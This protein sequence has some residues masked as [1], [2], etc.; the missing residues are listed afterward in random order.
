MNLKQ[1]NCRYYII[2]H[3]KTYKTSYIN[4][5][6]QVIILYDN[7]TPYNRPRYYLTI[8]VIMVFVTGLGVALKRV[9]IIH[10]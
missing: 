8:L 10:L 1:S 7:R 9:E 5:E 4:N 2:I 6:N 3:K